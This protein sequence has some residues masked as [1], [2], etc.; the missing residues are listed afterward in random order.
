MRSDRDKRSD[1]ER[2]IEDFLSQF[3]TPIDEIDTDVNSYLNNLNNFFDEAFIDEYDILNSKNHHDYSKNTDEPKLIINKDTTSEKI[4]TPIE[5]DVYSATNT[6]LSIDSFLSEFINNNSVSIE[7]TEPVIEESQHA[8]GVQLDSYIPIENGSV[9]PEQNDQEDIYNYSYSNIDDEPLITKEKIAADVEFIKNKM[10]GYNGDSLKHKLFLVENPN[11]DSSQPESYELN[12]KRVSNKPYKFSIKKLFFDC[13]GLGVAICLVVMLYCAIGILLA[14]S[15]DFHDVYSQ[16]DQSS[17]IY[18]NQGKQVD[19]VYYDQNRKISKYEDMP[20]DLINSFIA[21]EDKTFW[22]HHGFN[23]IRM[24]GAIVSSITG[25]GR[26][27]GTSTI[28]QQLARNVYLSDIK[29]VRSIK[30][31]VMEMYYASRLEACLSKEE[32]I[33]AYLNTIYLGYGCYGVNSASKAYFSKD[34]K[35]LD[36]VECAALAALPQAPDSYALVQIV[37]S[38]SVNEGDS[39]IIMREPN[40]V[41]A[42]DISK[43][44]RDICL[45]LMKNQGLIDDKEY[46]N[47]Y[48]KD[49]ID[50]ID[51]VV[52][53]GN[54]DNSY[55]HEYLVDTV[56]NDLV[57]KNHMTEE[58]ASRMIYTKGLKIYST[59]DSKAQKTIV[60]E[61][62]NPANYPGIST[63]HDSEGNIISQ[64]GVLLLYDYDNFFNS[65]GDFK[66]KK[67]EVKV[68]ADG[69]ITIMSGYR[70]NIY[71]IESGGMTD[72][73]LEFKQTYTTED[74]VLYAIPGGYINIPVDYKHLDS[75]GN[76]IISSQF[77]QDYPDAFKIKGNSV[78]ITNNIYS[79][80]QKTIQ[81][82][83]AMVIVGVGTGEI[84]AMVGGRTTR[85]ERLLNRATNPRQ[86]GSSIKPLA[87]YG[88]A[89]QKSFELCSA[90]KNWEYVDYDIDRQGTKGYGAYITTHSSVEDEKTKVNGETWPY[91]SNNHYSGRNTFM[92]AIQQSINTCAFKIQLQVGAEFSANML[93]KFGL[94]TIVT[95]ENEEVNDMNPAAMALGAMSHGVKPLEMALAYSVF[96]AGG[97]VNT[98][99]CYTKIEDRE[100]N[101]ILESKSEQSDVLDE[102][103]AWIMTK[104][105]QSVVTDGIA[106]AAYVDNVQSGG[107]TG[108]TDTQCDIWFDGFTPTYAASLWIGTDN[109]IPLTT[110]S[111]PAAALWG[112]IMRQLPAA[113][114]GTYKE[115]PANVVQKNGYYFTAGTEK[116]LDTYTGKEAKMME[117]EAK[118]RALEQWEME[119]DNLKTWIIDG[120]PY[121]ETVH[122][123]EVGHWD[124]TQDPPVWIIDEP[125]Y[126]EIIHHEPEGHW[127]Y[128]D[129]YK[130]GQFE[131]DGIIP[132]DLKQKY[133]ME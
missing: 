101:V 33:E 20:E 82:Q 55:F 39:N 47:A 12:G 16:V 31:K 38:G 111:G 108:T 6:A 106:G 128:P 41:I 28:T 46:K 54:G 40:T 62:N 49:L 109:N 125:E 69:S 126:D 51:P 74:G 7:N 24:C 19:Q 22:K 70:L 53:S 8:S 18:D 2:E 95:D 93:E 59:M 26:I 119:R 79:L 84:K 97:K 36:L 114:T 130:D 61:F 17:I 123:D 13:V 60:K 45:D 23:W 96:P 133:D 44:R 66:F 48:N 42:N 131:W 14:P 34:I 102:G 9:L 91:N 129:G 67:D 1:T 25:G 78:T 15:Y 3:D 100:G 113:C 83:S 124:E 10:K 117:A 52:S 27:S 77:F 110:M 120:E 58:D 86:P 105:L 5:E 92:T 35:Q 64:E 65:K 116:K 68:N 81:P 87:V 56:I 4:K 122:H 43:D 89:L 112:K 94:T 57:E 127:E 118:Q 115:M 132:D 32:I 37:D 72:Y 71:T 76:L 107:K 11:F 73:S 80:P 85:G 104:V 30:R 29:S 75:A 121:D 50:F 88:A 98:P 63:M 103:V 90:G 21:L 99:I